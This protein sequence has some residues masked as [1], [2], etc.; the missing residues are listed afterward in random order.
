MSRIGDF[1]SEIPKS[2]ESQFRQ[3]LCNRPAGRAGLLTLRF[4]LLYIPLNLCC[5]LI[6]LLNL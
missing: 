6:N 5:I 3:R 2:N 1:I 4:P